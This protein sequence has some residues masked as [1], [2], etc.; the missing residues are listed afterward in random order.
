[1]NTIFLGLIIVLQIFILIGIYRTNDRLNELSSNLTPTVL[2]NS[3][4]LGLIS[5]NM[6]RITNIFSQLADTINTM[7]DKLKAK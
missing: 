6:K 3:V 2:P 5:E 4:A 1:M 7:V